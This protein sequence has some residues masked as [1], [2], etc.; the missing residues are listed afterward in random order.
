MAGTMPHAIFIETNADGDGTV[1]AYAAELPGCATYARTDEE[2]AAAL[3]RRVERFCAWLRDAG[4]AAPSFLGDNWYE[5]ERA[6]AVTGEDGRLLRAAFSLDELPPSDTEFERWLSWLELAREELAAALDASG[7]S[8]PV[9]TLTGIAEQDLALAAALGA[10]PADVAG[11]SGGSD[12]DPVDR[13]YAARDILTDA[14]AA[15][16]A[17]AEGVRRAVRLAIADDLRAA[18]DLRGASA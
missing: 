5:V 2:A 4:E 1:A 9:E 17:S 6:A 14:L 15:A 10:V 8:V 13:L 7:E 16:G 11:I 12:A 18:D 3:P